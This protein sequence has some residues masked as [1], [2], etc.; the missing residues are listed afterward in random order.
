MNRP[1]AMACRMTLLTPW[2]RGR[3]IAL[4]VNEQNV[5]EERTLTVVR[6]IGS[7][8]IVSAGLE[9]GDRIIVEG[10]QM[11]GVGMTVVP[12]ERQPTQTQTEN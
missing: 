2:W 5:I 8:W 9:D 10:L 1:K 3:P 6:N 11:V 7:D 4:V 12:E